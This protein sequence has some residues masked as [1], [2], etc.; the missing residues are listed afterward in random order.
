MTEKL[1][2]VLP[3]RKRRERKTMPQLMRL[4]LSNPQ[5]I[6]EILRAR[7]LDGREVLIDDSGS[8]VAITPIISADETR[9]RFDQALANIELD[10]NAVLDVDS[11][12]WIETMKNARVNKEITVHFD[13]EP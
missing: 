7:N 1:A 4:D 12:W 10:P 11:E 13:D 3:D 9:S 5:T 6:I 8:R 2:P